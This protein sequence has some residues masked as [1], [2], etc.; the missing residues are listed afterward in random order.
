VSS[1]AAAAIPAPAWTISS[2]AIP[3][4]FAPG[5]GDN[6]YAL[7]V[8]NSGGSVADAS[9]E[10]I[11]VTD[12]L[13]PGLEAIEIAALDKQQSSGSTTCTLPSLVCS[14]AGTIEPGRFVTVYVL[15]RVLGGAQPQETNLA[16]VSGGGAPSA[17]TSEQTPISS[18]P[19]GFGIQSFAFA[20]PESD[21][22][23]SRQAGGHPF[24][25]TATFSLDTVK[26]EHSEHGENSIS[27]LP[28]LNPKDVEVDLPPG[29]IGNPAAIPRCG[30][31][32]QSSGS[33]PAD[34]QVG[35]AVVFLGTG[36]PGLFP[37]VVTPLISEKPIYNVVPREDVPAE[38]AFQIVETRTQIAGRVRS[39]GNFS[40]A[41]I[42]RNLSE[43]ARV[44]GASVTFWGV[45]GD[46]SH[47]PLRTLQCDIGCEG[48]GASFTSS[49]KPFLTNPT[50]C[51]A[52]QPTT[53]TA[54]PWQ[55]IGAFLTASVPSPQLIGCDR[56]AFAPTITAAS[57]PEPARA[58]TPAALA[59][60]LK[61]PQ[62]D[63]TTSLA[64]P[65]LKDATVTLPQGMTVSP[66]SADGLAAC[67]A[68]GLQGIN[69]GSGQ[70]APNGQ[71]LSQPEATERDSTGFYVPAPGHCP[72]AS[73][74]GTVEVFTPLLAQPLQGHIYLG[75]PACSPCTN[76]DAEEGK[77]LK[78]YIEVAGS[79]VIVKLPGS[80]SVDPATGRIAASFENTPQLPFEELKVRFKSGPRAALVNPPICGT[81]TTTSDLTPWSAPETPD[82]TPSDSFQVDEGCSAPGFAPAFSAGTANNQAG[83][84][85]PFS[86][87]FSR[88][89]Q[90]QQL[91]GIRVTTPP[92][93]LGKLAGVPLCGE[94]Q[95]ALGT[96]S[97]ASQIGHTTVGAGA[98]SSPIYLPVA[99]QPPNPVYLT[100]GYKG[101]PFG[102][103][104]VV[105]AIAGPFNLGN[106]VVRA[107]ISVDPHTSQITITSDP[108]PT[109][110]DGIP[111]R[112]R[113]VD[114]TVDRPGFMFNPTNCNPLAINGTLTSTQ[115]ASAAVSSR[116]QAANCASLPFKPSL[117]ASTEG[118]TSK[119]NGASLTVKIA[120]AGIGQAGIAK[121][122]LTIP[123]ILPSRL[124][125]LQKACTDAQFNAN[126][127]G[128]PAASNIA[129]AT[130]HTPLLNSPLSGP[131]YFVSH[132]GAA[133]PDTEIVL[134]GEGVT[135]IL[136][137]HTQIKKGVTYSLFESVPDAPFTSFEFNAPEG[138]HSIFGANGNLC[139]TEVRMPATL[140]AQNGAVINQQTLVKP[141]GCPNKLTI[142]S[143]TVKKRTLTLKVAVPG[144][145]KLTATG[146]GLSKASKSAKG[147]SIVTL[148]LRAKG[149]A[150]HK[151][152]VKLTFAPSKGRRLT[153]AVV[154]RFRR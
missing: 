57:E 95:A 150:K 130:V 98:G 114:V 140:V 103:S 22:S 39:D 124:S 3:T 149:H 47:D 100:T 48:G 13:P 76:R 79:G 49:V 26:E 45:P 63:A 55:Q 97:A 38:F 27:F 91:S 64:T 65:A 16:T 6:L 152:K 11:T 41:T 109:I 144:A 122:D 67:Q 68:S 104:V 82:A 78:L 112:V 102:L 23:P 4:N 88:T 9:V 35:E 121:V 113:T 43:S 96:C 66:S 90:D 145:G 87:T 53:L 136:E 94:P 86:V 46:S 20:T 134:Q 139:E 61:V 110:L 151:S 137:G 93:L 89:D 120:S 24:D 17:S 34:S 129:T 107:A 118:K 142:L 148:T 99:G 29:L 42:S 62:T 106:V 54:D 2:T 18:T 128:C 81:Y 56:L 59:V 126:P 19:A 92:G 105:P 153:A 135:L 40:V 32:E 1:A 154:A 116:F 146:K 125:T 119:A 58:D 131:V 111:L 15:V 70:L 83:A 33:C 143:R 14:F 77:L 74:L 80:A 21:G 127:A 10:P 7:T 60:D 138:P 12:A 73:T 5:S 30:V 25:A 8:I 123:A 51:A 31:A 141:E 115:G 44:R 85:S 101:A 69:L 133:F 147:R 72:L 75:A 71:D 84:F 50:S 36:G 28:A 117:T 52:P 108:L 37:E 132:G